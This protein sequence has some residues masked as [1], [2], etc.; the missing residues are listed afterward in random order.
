M[1]RI[2]FLLFTLCSLVHAQNRINI[3]YERYIL[4]NGL[5]IILHEDHS[6]PTVSVNIW[7]HVGSAY[8]KVGHTGFAH[9]FE[10]L[11]FEGS[12]HVAEGDFDGLLESVGGYNNASTNR[13]RT[14]YFENVPSN[15]L[16]LAL[17]LDSDRMGFLLDSMS[18]EKVDGQREVVKN[19]RRQRYENSPYGL[20][21]ENIYKNLYPEGYPYNWTT[22]GS[23]ADLDAASY[24]DVAEFFKTFYVPNNA[25]LVIAGDINANEAL[26][27]VEKWFGG[28]PAGEPVPSLNP[29]S[30]KLNEEKIITIEDNVQLPRLYMTWITPP[31]FAPGDADMDILSN[32]FSQGK[33]S[34]LYKKLIYEMQIAQDVTAFQSSGKLSSEFI[35][36]ATARA[37]HNLEELK[38]AIQEEINKIK[39]KPPSQREL[40]RAVNQYEAS[41]LDDLEKP[42]RKAD[43]LNLYFYYTGNPDYSNEAISR[44]RALSPDDIQ[45]AA[46]TYLQDNSRVVL[47]IVPKGKTDLAVQTKTEGK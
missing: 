28:L 30:A 31:F 6:T 14:N 13:D 42:D 22:I 35:I 26:K 11:M 10:H 15:A 19:E 25:S 23:M 44:Y 21:W 5:N 4:P 3:P 18:A 43:L 38:N 36:I 45:A 2:I 20:A 9:L 1:K 33:N 39:L 47:S 40:E 12:G 32:I 24:N 17:Y 29:E 46:L 27:L 37:G 8:E 16:E 7:Y 41:F 34:R